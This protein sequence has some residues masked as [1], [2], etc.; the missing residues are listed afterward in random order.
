M[1]IAETL[2]DFFLCSC[3]GKCVAIWLSYYCSANGRN[4]A[5]NANSVNE[6]WKQ[7]LTAKIYGYSICLASRFCSTLSKCP[8]TWSDV[9]QHLFGRTS[10]TTCLQSS[11]GSTLTYGAPCEYA[12][13]LIRSI[14]S[15][16]TRV[17][18]V[19]HN[20][21]HSPLRKQLYLT[22][23]LV[24]SGLLSLNLIFSSR[25]F[26]ANV[27]Y[28][29]LTSGLSPFMIRHVQFFL[30][31]G[32]TLKHTFSQQL[33]APPSGKLQRIR[34]TAE[35]NGVLHRLFLRNVWKG[36]I[37]MFNTVTLWYPI[38]SAS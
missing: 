26:H 27:R 20:F 28:L 33:S 6:S 4:N 36:P 5:N 14:D 16:K 15:E 24:L 17:K 19:S 34:F 10:A 32:G 18:I 2:H 25:S 35:I 9:I 21:G 3:N 7:D 8:Q 29:E 1:K 11:P 37:L 31:K 12:L 30:N 23:L 22:V 38:A 13:D